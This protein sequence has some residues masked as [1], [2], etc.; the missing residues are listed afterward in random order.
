[1]SGY[2]DDALDRWRNRF[3]AW[4]EGRTPAGA[5]LISR[6]PPP[7]HHGR[8][9]FCYFDNDVK[10]M[11]PRDAHALAGRISGTGGNIVQ[12][13]AIGDA[14]TPSMTKERLSGRARSS[15]PRAGTGSVARKS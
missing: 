4:S 12:P 11:A 7:A 2:G 1:M 8:D 13:A 5:H 14:A 10:V 9:D 6:S 3:V 15:W